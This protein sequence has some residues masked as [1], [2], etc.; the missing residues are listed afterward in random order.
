MRLKALKK[1]C[2]EWWHNVKW[3]T[4]IIVLGIHVWRPGGENVVKV[5]RKA[6]AQKLAQKCWRRK[7]L[8][9]KLN[10]RISLRRR[11]RAEEGGAGW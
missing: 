1:I 7:S 11:C 3:R 9:A 6:S 8:S 10:I 5:A 2:V 4:T